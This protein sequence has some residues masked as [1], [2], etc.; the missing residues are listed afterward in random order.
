MAEASSDSAVTRVWF[1]VFF[2]FSGVY[3]WSLWH[4]SGLGPFTSSFTEV[5]S[6]E[7]GLTAKVLKHLTWRVLIKL[8]IVWPRFAQDPCLALWLHSSPQTSPRA[9]QGVDV[10]G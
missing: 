3:R 8:V 2:C 5:S 4:P 7:F 6:G 9:A 10:R 1:W